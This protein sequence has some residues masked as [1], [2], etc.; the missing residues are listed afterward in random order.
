MGQGRTEKKKV[1]RINRIRMGIETM[2]NGYSKGK[3]KRGEKRVRRT[4]LWGKKREDGQEGD[5]QSTVKMTAR[6][7]CE[8]FN[9]EWPKL[10]RP[11]VFERNESRNKLR[12]LLK[13]T[14]VVVSGGE[15]MIGIFHQS[16]YD[17][18][19]RKFV[20]YLSQQ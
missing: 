15:F 14:Y 11:A 2:K 16:N 10:F 1:E 19:A 18:E 12:P 5:R 4:S 9:S 8:N 7:Y 13:P 3:R 6:G 20:Q 17:L